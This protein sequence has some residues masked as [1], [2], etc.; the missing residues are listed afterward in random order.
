MMMCWQHV[1]LPQTSVAIKS[2]TKVLLHD[3]I[4]KKTTKFRMV[5]NQ[6]CNGEYSVGEVIRKT[7][8][9][10]PIISTGKNKW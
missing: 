5:A 10:G 7:L 9:Y 1:S 4:E 2:N 8:W 6:N 3:V